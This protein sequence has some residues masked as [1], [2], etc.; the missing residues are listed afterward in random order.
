MSLKCKSEVGV[1]FF[2]II[3]SENTAFRV[4]VHC[5]RIQIVLSCF[6]DALSPKPGR[7]LAVV[8]NPEE[9]QGGGKCEISLPKNV[10]VGFTFPFEGLL[11]S[12]LASGKCR[13]HFKVYFN[14]R[15]KSQLP[16]TNRKPGH[17]VCSK[18]KRNSLG[19]SLLRYS[20]RVLP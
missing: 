9:K 14:S 4:A 19:Y 20:V 10:V 11:I 18:I 12:A 3:C 8:P 7:Q 5:P 2:S 1:T 15:L 16:F 13:L 6:Y 17:F